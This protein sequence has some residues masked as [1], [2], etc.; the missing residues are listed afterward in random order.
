MT[1]ATKAAEAQAE[2]R[3][4]ILNPQRMELA[5]QWRQDWVVN[6]EQGT[7]IGDV[8]DPQYWS[9][10]AYRMQPYDHIEVRLET[11]E[12]LLQLLVLSVGRNYVQVYLMVKHDLQGVGEDAP[13]AM[14]HKV[15][16]KGPQHKW[17]VTR[18][19]DSQA[20][21]SG[22]ESKEIANTW[23]SNHERVVAKT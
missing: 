7:T 12:W 3:V 23:L 2:K 16:W 11:G 8:L 21:Q 5:E 22:L 17:V 18:L 15:E 9:H 6:A 4:V 13:V 20:I 19:A 14:K 10:M 1:D